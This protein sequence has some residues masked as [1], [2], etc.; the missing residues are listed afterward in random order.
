MGITLIA[1]VIGLCFYMAPHL[2]RQSQADMDDRFLSFLDMMAVPQNLALLGVLPLLWALLVIWIKRLHDRNR[3]AAW[4][5]L[6]FVPVIGWLWLLIEAG[7][8]AGTRGH[9]RF[10]PSPVWQQAQRLMA[11]ADAEEDMA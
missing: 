6:L 8:R 1:G 11:A 9:N 3:S 10:G 5:L 2:V 7:L 4:M